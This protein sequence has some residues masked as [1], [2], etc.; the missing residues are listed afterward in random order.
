MRT[1][2]IKTIEKLRERSPLGFRLTKAISCLDPAVVC[3]LPLA[4]KRLNACLEILVDKLRMSGS[5]ADRV[6]TEYLSLCASPD[7]QKAMS[8]YVCSETRLDKF[9]MEILSKSPKPCTNL[10]DFIQMILIMSHGNATAERGF[11]VNE[12]GLVENQSELSLVA[13]RR[14]YDA[15]SAAGGVES[16]KITKAFILSMRNAHCK[17]KDH[18]VSERKKREAESEAAAEAKRKQGIIKQLEDEKSAFVASAAKKVAQ[19]DDTINALKK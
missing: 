10:S 3:R 4:Q 17:Y 12:E 6:K 7:V 9:W 1:C 13:Q 16:V 5:K 2:L 18:M 8:K 14:V 15:V 11:S 19:L